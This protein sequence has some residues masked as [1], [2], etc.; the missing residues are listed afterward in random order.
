MQCFGHYF[1]NIFL[2]Y[3][4][5]LREYYDLNKV[6]GP[7]EL[8]ILNKISFWTYNLC[9]ITSVILLNRFINRII[10]KLK[11][12]KKTMKLNNSYSSYKTTY[13]PMPQH[14]Y[15]NRAIIYQ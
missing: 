11:S 15:S 6:P 14:A 13:D 12:Y 9:S 4:K 5:E 7:P 1:Y 2:K 8:P 10:S 3:S